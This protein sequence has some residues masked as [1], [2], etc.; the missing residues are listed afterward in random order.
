[1]SG[2]PSHYMGPQWL[3]S[4]DGGLYAENTAHHRRYD[5]RFLA[6]LPL[7]PADRVLDLGCGAGDLTAKVAALV[8]D[9]HVVGVDP[10]PSLLAEAATR[11]AAN[12][13][14]VRAA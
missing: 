3:P 14:F 2:I 11:A 7:A 4:W 5:D 13:S 1:M 8:P 9:G 10:Q 6:T 12:Q